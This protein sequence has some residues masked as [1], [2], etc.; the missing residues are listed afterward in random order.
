[1]KSTLENARNLNCFLCVIGWM[2]GMFLQMAFERNVASKHSV[3]GL[4]L[5]LETFLDISLMEA[6]FQDFMVEIKTGKYTSAFKEKIW[7]RPNTCRIS[8]LIPA[9]Q[10]IR[11]KNYIHTAPQVYYRVGQPELDKLFKRK[12]RFDQTLCSDQAISLQVHSI[13][14]SHH[15]NCY[16][17]FSVT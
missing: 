16:L 5:L 7:I 15:P 12:L 11:C 4:I 13:N 9:P 1:M 3:L 14:C 6:A 10:N 8:L 17:I 2:F